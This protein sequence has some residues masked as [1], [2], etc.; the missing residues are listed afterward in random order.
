MFVWL[1]A[2]LAVHLQSVRWCGW[3]KLPPLCVR[4]V[5]NSNLQ[6]LEPTCCSW[7]GDKLM[8]ITL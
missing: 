5:G 2:T 6:Q 8:T 3:D 1:G 7:R 4:F